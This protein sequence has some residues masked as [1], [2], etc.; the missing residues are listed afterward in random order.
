MNGAG[1]IHDAEVA[2]VGRT[3]EDVDEVLGCGCFGMARETA[4][5]F[6]PR[7]RLGGAAWFGPGPGGGRRLLES[8]FPH[9]DLS[10]VAA[11]A[12]LEA[13]L[14]VH[15]AVGTDIIHLH[16]SV[17]PEALAPRAIWI[18]AVRGPG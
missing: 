10:L 15:V 3:S 2:M 6:E 11:A 4:E 8:D 17:A 5:I 1:I 18:F 12:A 13:S 7:H 9:K 16:P 14:T